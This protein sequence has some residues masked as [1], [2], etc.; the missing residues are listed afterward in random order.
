MEAQGQLRRDKID[1]DT[2]DRKETSRLSAALFAPAPRSHQEAS[3][4]FEILSHKVFIKLCTSQ[5]PHKSIDLSFII[6]IY[7]TS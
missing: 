3:A 6:S 7:R 2:R 5:S 1:Q 4:G